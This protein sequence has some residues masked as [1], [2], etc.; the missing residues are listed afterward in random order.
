MR[1]RIKMLEQKIDELER[2]VISLAQTVAELSE[3]V[4]DHEKKLSDVD[5]YVLT[6][7]NETVDRI[8]REMNDGINQVLNFTPYGVK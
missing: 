1:K 4:E 5:G 3:K 6:L 7:F 2:M 8:G